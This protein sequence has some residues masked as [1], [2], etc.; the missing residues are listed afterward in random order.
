MYEKCF[1]LFFHKFKSAIF[2]HFQ[3]Q[4]FLSF[5]DPSSPVLP[6]LFCR[7]HRGLRI[8]SWSFKLV[9]GKGSL[10]HG[11]THRMVLLL[12]SQLTTRI[13]SQAQRNADPDLQVMIKIMATMSNSPVFL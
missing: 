10:F 13:D 3:H 8:L 1:L 7:S 11:E 9:K 2:G 6:F 4:C 12:A 5:A